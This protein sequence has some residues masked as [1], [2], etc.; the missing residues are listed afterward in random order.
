M[1]LI[2]GTAIFKEHLSMA[3][4][5]SECLWSRILDQA[6]LS[7]LR[8]LPGCEPLQENVHDESILKKSSFSLFS[9][10]LQQL[11]GAEP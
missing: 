9:L 11:M 4:S 8:F 1:L 10:S 3:A 2:K 5:V 6:L 7:Y